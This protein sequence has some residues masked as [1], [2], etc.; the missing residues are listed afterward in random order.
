MEARA[1][2]Q[3]TS[4]ILDGD[5]FLHEGRPM[6]GSTAA[7]LRMMPKKPDGSRYSLMIRKVR[8]HPE[9]PVTSGTGSVRR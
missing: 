2:I 9:S 3:G 7:V 6:A 5:A 1:A 4:F 8:C